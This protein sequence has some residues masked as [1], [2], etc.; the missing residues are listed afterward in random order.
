MRILMLSDVYFPRINGVSTS[1]KT[2][3]DELIRQGHQVLLIVP[4]YETAYEDDPDI[5]RIASRRVIGDP[6]DRMMRRGAIKQFSKHITPGQFDMVHIQTPFVAHN[7][8][9]KIAQLLNLPCVESYHTL[10]EEYL[11]HYIPYCPKSLLR[12]AARFFTR[13]QCKKVGIVIAPSHQMREVL[14]DYGVK[15]P[16]EVLPTGIPM[17]CFKVADGNVFRERYNIEK[18]RPTLVHVGRIAHE[19]NI[20]FLIEVLREVRQQIPD[21]LLIVAGEGPALSL[22]KKIAHKYGLSGNILFVGYLSRERDLLDC[23]QAGDCFVFASKTETQG[24]VLLEAMAL[25][26]PVVSIAYLGTRDILNCERGAVVAKDE[27]ADFSNRVIQLL[28][29][30]D[31]RKKIGDEGKSYATEWS[32]SHLAKRLV[33]LYQELGRISNKQID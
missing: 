13:G 23:Y 25:G 3:R 26:V 16:I 30:P 9:I 24:L 10:F 28:Y 14:I 22:I 21:V 18:D 15:T 7:V 29:N 2:F 8:G 12:F 27:V 17:Q 1:I 32:A 20:G 5:I 11:Y 33:N 19:K 31:R 6:E 4:E